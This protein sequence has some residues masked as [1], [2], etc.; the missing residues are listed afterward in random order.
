MGVNIITGSWYLGSFVGYRAAED[1]W[2][3]ENF[4]GLA[5]SAKTLAG[6]AH[7]HLQY[8]YAGIQKSLQQEW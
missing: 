2:L 3:A 5:E 6:G 8:A 7:K 1:S 4:Q